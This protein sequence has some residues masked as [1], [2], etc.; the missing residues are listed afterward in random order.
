M[1]FLTEFARKWDAG[2]VAVARAITG[3]IVPGDLAAGD[4]NAAE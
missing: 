1:P 2:D 3:P 4:G